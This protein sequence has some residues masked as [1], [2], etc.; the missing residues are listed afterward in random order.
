MLKQNRRRGGKNM[1]G[2]RK[3]REQLA[4]QEEE[5]WNLQAWLRN[6]VQE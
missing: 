5:E 6:I 1:R 2:G 4:E 3:Y